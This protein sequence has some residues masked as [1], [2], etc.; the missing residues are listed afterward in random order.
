MRKLFTSWQ[1]LYVRKN[2][3]KILC[4]IVEMDE[5]YIVA[6]HK[7]ILK[8]WL[9]LKGLEGGIASREREEG[10]RCPR[11]ATRLLHAG[12]GW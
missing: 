7:A 5:V 12:K 11:K 2:L 9:R 3:Q 4:G 8:L 6:E 1:K 10:A